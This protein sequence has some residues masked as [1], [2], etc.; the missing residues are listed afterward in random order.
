MADA[1]AAGK[2]DGAAVAGEFVEVA[3]ETEAAE[4]AAE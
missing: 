4:A 3:E 2:N 1:C